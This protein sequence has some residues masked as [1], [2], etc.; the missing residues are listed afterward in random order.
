[1]SDLD[2]I[3]LV[4]NIMNNNPTFKNYLLNKHQ[5]KVNSIKE[6]NVADILYEYIFWYPGNI[7]LGPNG[8][9]RANDPGSNVD[10]EIIDIQ[11]S[12]YKSKIKDIYNMINKMR[13]S[14][15]KNT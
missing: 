4:N 14:N 6:V 5:P 8:T 13:Q 11:D 1:M 9:D 3:D 10:Q 12:Q 7:V 2:L 15:N